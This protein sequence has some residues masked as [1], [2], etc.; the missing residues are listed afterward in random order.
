[1]SP[2]YFLLDPKGEALVV[3]SQPSYT[4]TRSSVSCSEKETLR[5][6]SETLPP[7]PHTPKPPSFLWHCREAFLTLAEMTSKSSPLTYQSTEEVS[8]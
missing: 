8:A 6:P 5:E 7:Q 4:H 3:K 2:F 1:M